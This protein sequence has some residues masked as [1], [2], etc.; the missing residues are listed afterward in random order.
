MS[1][2][3]PCL[4]GHWVHSREE[5]SAGIRT[6]RPGGWSLP[7]SRAPR[8]VLEFA[9]DHRVVS[10]IGGPA[11]ARIAREGRW[12]VESGQPILLRLVWRDTSQPVL[13]EVITCLK[14][15]LQVRV[16]SGSIE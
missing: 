11:D 8:Q 10:R 4:Q 6:Y 5:D 7:R 1:P 14:E 16:V 3:L 2:G 9:P 12:D 13:I 15:L